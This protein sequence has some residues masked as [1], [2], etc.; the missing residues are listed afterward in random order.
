MDLRG[1]GEQRVVETMAGKTGLAMRQEP[2]RAKG[3]V[4]VDRMDSIAE[5]RDETVEPLVQGAGAFGLADAGSLNG[6]FELDERGRR[7]EDGILVALNPI[8]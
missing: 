2:A 4:D 8:S 1:R 5:G 7:E 3:D 6:G